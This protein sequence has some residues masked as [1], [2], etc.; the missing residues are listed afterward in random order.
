M[1]RV[2]FGRPRCA[3]DVAQSVGTQFEI[4]SFLFVQS[5]SITGYPIGDNLFISCE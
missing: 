3:G 2:S 1:L 4:A 5:A